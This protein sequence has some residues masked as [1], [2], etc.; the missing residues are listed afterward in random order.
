MKMKL[1]WILFLTL[2]SLAFLAF[3][4]SG[5]DDDDDNDDDNLGDDDTGDENADNLCDETTTVLAGADTVSELVGI[6]ADDLLDTTGGG[7]TTA[8]DYSGDTSFLTQ[9][10]AG[11][12]TDLTVTIAY[13]GGE[14]RQIESVPAAGDDE[15]QSEIGWDCRHRLEVEVTLGFATADGAFAE[16]WSAVLAQAL[17]DDQGNLAAPTLAGEFDPLSLTGSFEILSI[18]GPTPD[19]VTGAL[20]STAVDPYVGGLDILVEQSQGVGDEGTVSQTR[21]VALAWG[22]YQ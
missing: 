13:N 6:S 4:C 18:E 21:H 8:A 14:I 20:A 11:T 15:S 2:A 16:S 22:G 1:F 5:D 9:S 17:A 10:P 7:F 19:A 12:A 3:A